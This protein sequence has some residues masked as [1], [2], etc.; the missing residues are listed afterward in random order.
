MSMWVQLVEI[1]SC[2]IM[3]ES[4]GLIADIIGV[5]GSIFAGFAWWQARKTNQDLALEKQRLNKTIPIKLVN[6]GR[7]IEIPVHLK[8]A[9][10]TRAEILGRLG[11][12]PVKPSVERYKIRYLNNPDFFIQI[13]QIVEGTGSGVLTIPVSE[14]EFD[15]F[16]L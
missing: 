16:D 9:D 3:F 14:E 10:F 6:G 2:R 13:N 7:E 8:R 12:L 4:L 15:Q 11:M 5:L 1:G